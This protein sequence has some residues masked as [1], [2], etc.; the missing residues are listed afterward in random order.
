MLQLRE[1][2]GER[3]F[4]KATQGQLEAEKAELKSQLE[5]LTQRAAKEQEASRNEL[6]AMEKKLAESEARIRQLELSLEKWKAAYD[7]V[8]GIAK[9][10]ETEREELAAQKILNERRIA[11]L[12]TK[13]RELYT[14][15]NE[16]LSRYKN[17]GLGTALTAREPFVGITR[18]KLQNLVQDY[19]DELLENRDRPAA[20]NSA[21]QTAAQ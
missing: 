2:Q 13:N 1:A 17:F 12:E 3:D 7:K 16:I 4:L 14:T 5:T 21:T 19:Q 8:A 11:D 10:K 18:V 9:E 15:G 20:P 6:L